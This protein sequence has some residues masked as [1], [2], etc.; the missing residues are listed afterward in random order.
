VIWSDS[1]GEMKWKGLGLGLVKGLASVRD[2]SDSGNSSSM[3]YIQ[4]S[5]IRTLIYDVTLG[6]PLF[7]DVLH[8]T[9]LRKFQE[10]FAVF[11]LIE[12]FVQDFNNQQRKA[13]REKLHNHVLIILSLQEPRLPCAPK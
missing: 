11:P 8:H 13:E 4:C 6:K 10:I 7:I 1:L 3:R 12:D 9:A 2:P 5:K